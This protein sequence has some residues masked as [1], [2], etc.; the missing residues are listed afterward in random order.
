MI[1]LVVEVDL[2]RFDTAPL[3]AFTVAK[4]TDYWVETDGRIPPR[5]SADCTDWRADAE[6]SR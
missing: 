2:S 3:I 4:E 1:A 6:T 5:C